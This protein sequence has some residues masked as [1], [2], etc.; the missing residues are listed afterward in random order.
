MDAT[1]RDARL[2]VSTIV[3]Q[4]GA[5]VIAAGA[6][7]VLLADNL[8]P[9]MGWPPAGTLRTIGLVLALYGAGLARQARSQ[10]HDRR[11][12]MTAAV[13]NL[14]YAAAS[15]IVPFA[16]GAPLTTIGW[17]IIALFAAVAAGF[18]IAQIRA[19]RS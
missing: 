18:A 5:V 15:I 8:A 16:L 4:D 13:V 17:V 3:L 11:L 7:I 14:A 6:A 1:G 9:L 19:A 10:P 2:P 12:P